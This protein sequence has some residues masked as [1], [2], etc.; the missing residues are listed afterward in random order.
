MGVF[1]G[2]DLDRR[3]LHHVEPADLIKPEGVIDV[4]VREEDRVAARQAVPQRLLPKVRP[5]VDE[6][7]AR[8]ACGIDK[9]DG[10]GRAQA[11][12]ARIGRSADRA[13]AADGGH[14][15]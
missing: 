4:V 8:A 5:G 9:L 12:V 13:P 14:A 11:R 10:G 1:L 15:R 3:L 6:D 2:V 7:R